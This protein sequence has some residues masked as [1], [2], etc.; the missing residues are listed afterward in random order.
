MAL[1]S[2]SSASKRTSSGSKFHECTGLVTFPS[3]HTSLAIITAYA[4]RGI[5]FVATPVAILNGI[6]I[7]STLPEGGHY[8]IDLIAGAIISTI[9]IVAI[10]TRYLT[11]TSYVARLSV[12]FVFRNIR[13]KLWR[14][15]R[16]D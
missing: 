2:P 16:I 1:P 14:G 7:I 8:L 10:R 4:V 5:K 12:L 11:Y 9:A 3:F 13:K 6:V 15:F